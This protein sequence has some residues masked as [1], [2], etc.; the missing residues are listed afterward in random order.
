MR[1]LI[2]S[3]AVLIPLSA[4]CAQAQAQATEDP[5]VRAAAI[6]AQMTQ[7]ERFVLTHGMLAL[8]LAGK[9]PGDAV[10]GAGYV[11]GIP[12][13]RVPP[14]RET[15]ATL[16]VA[17]LGGLRGKEGATPLPS[18]LALAS[19]WNPE[20]ARQAGE[21][22]GLE[23]KQK[24]F[25]VL[26]A[27]GVNLV[28]EPRNG[29]SFEYLSEDPLLTGILGGASIAGIQSNGIISTIKHFALNDQETARNY[30]DV[31]ISEANARESDLLAFQIAIERGDPGAVMCAYNLVNGAYTCDSDWLLNK[32]LKQD[33]RYKGFVMSDWG[34]VPGVST[35]MNGLDQQSGSQLDKAVFLNK[36][37]KEAAAA[38]PRVASRV[39]E[40]NR[41]I[42]RSM[43]AHGLESTPPVPTPIDVKAGLA[44]AQNVA[45][46]G[47]VLLRNQRNVLPL[48]KAAKKIAVIGGYADT[49][50]LSGGG[51]SQV[52][53]TGGPAI[54]IPVGGDV[55]EALAVLLPG[56]T[57]HRSNPLKA[58]RARAAGSQ[59]S[60]TNG[61]YISEAVDAA[62]GADVVIVFAT[63]W[64]TENRDVPDLTLPNGQDALIAA[65]AKSNPNTVVVLE[66][67]G[68]ILMPWLDDTAAV[69]EAWYP[70]GGGGEAI[71]SILFGET[72]PSGKLPVTF[73]RSIENLPRKIIEGKDLPTNGMFPAP[74]PPGVTYRADYD[75]DG[76]DV[77]YRWYA[78]ENRPTLFPFG[79]GLSYT[80]FQTSG[81]H[82]DGKVARFT[83]RNTGSRAGATV[84]Q[85]YL[86]S[87]AGERRRRLVAFEKVTLQPGQSRMITASIDPRLLAEW[88]QGHWKVKAGTY[89]FALGSDAETLGPTVAVKMRSSQWTERGLSHMVP[90][91]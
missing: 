9:L 37:L 1:N 29:R 58:I 49:G 5:D 55:P 57:Y 33:W 25:N 12:R 47:I 38:D 85:V 80:S 4:S 75:I 84:E 82:T 32:V 56:E 61:R 83:V 39:R 30:V 74:P 76:S 44:V 90:R 53:M 22:I 2:I 8:P 17:Y 27:G 77:G 81:F 86:V 23:A 42:L 79:F 46:E 15:D 63:E 10:I 59:V 69:V 71:A 41:R 6:E 87:A 62:K 14:L 13:L 34:S 3:A 26:L 78:R 28:R 48:S 40:M 11:A 66:T 31:R 89:G 54:T 16:G 36:P 21:T 72:N 50:V 88:E 67:G 70:G 35:A 43:F 45:K 64:R 20:L 52:Q 91:K 60:F 18:G 24:G 68:P 65:V 19:S 51:S 73:P 7:E